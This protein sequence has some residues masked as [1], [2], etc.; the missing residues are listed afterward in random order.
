MLQYTPWKTEQKQ[1]DPNNEIQVEEQ[2]AFSN[3]YI[4]Q[5]AFFEEPYSGEQHVGTF[6]EGVLH[7]GSST[8]LEVPN[9]A[10]ISLRLGDE[11]LDLHHWRVETFYRCL[12]KGDVTLERRFTAT[13]PKGYTVEVTA[14]RQLCVK[15]PHLMEL[16]YS[17]KFINYQGLISFMALMGDNSHQDQWYPLQ[18]SV[19]DEVAYMWIQATEGDIQLCGAQRHALYKNGVIQPDRPVKIDKKRVLGFAYMTDVEPGDTFTMKTGVAI[20]DSHRYAKAELPQRAIE[21]LGMMQASAE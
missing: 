5:Y 9:P 7:A 6:V 1:F 14:K 13:S 15:N 20:V 8:P 18:T 17:V 21:K 2:L 16:E 19:D 11:R 10:I 3:G 4:S 12:H